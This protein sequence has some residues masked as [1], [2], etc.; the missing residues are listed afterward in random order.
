MV[1]RDA[2]LIV[3]RALKLADMV[4]G[5]AE[6]AMYRPLPEE[7]YEEYAKRVN[8]PLPDEA[9]SLVKYIRRVRLYAVPESLLPPEL[10]DGEL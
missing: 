4:G 2:E 3:L 10:P 1:A 7:T 5:D 9:D 6:R 8:Q